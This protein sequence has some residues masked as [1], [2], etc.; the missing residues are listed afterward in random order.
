M[1]EPGEETTERLTLDG[2]LRGL[3]RRLRIIGYDCEFLEE[4]VRSERDLIRLVENRERRL[5]TTSRHL[6][7]LAPGRICLAPAE[8]LAEQVRTVVERS[9]IDFGRSAF[10]RCALDNALLEVLTFEEAKEQLPP[11]VREMRPEP[12]LHCPA[13]GRYYW[14]GT[15]VERIIEDFKKWTGIELEFRKMK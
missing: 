13:C 5:V 10:S 3:G 7:S 4:S 6:H 1:A 11:L 8:G 15:H 12:V 14:P 2:M 9:P